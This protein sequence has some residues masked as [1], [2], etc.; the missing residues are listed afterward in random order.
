MAVSY[1]SYHDTPG[2][3]RYFDISIH[4]AHHYKCVIQRTMYP[5]ELV[6]ISAL[7]PWHSLFVGIK[8]AVPCHSMKYT[9]LRFTIRQSYHLLYK[10]DWQVLLYVKCGVL[11]FIA[12]A[13]IN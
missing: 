1:D 5:T 7:F 6:E 2:V 12:R 9:R 11:C 4:I 3:S 8:I 10:Q 13:D